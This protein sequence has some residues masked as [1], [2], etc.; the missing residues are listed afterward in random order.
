MEA[1]KLRHKVTIQ[2]VDESSR[3][4]TGDTAKA[5]TPVATVSAEVIHMTNAAM[6]AERQIAD[7]QIPVYDWRV[8]IR[9]RTDVDAKNRIK[10]VNISA[11]TTVYFD[12]QSVVD[13]DE[14]RAK[15][16]LYCTEHKT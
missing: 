4:G 9:R 14:R 13:A 12:I 5:W 15:M 1:G 8:T 10:Y 6:R 3:T 7:R 11:D 16:I 2:V